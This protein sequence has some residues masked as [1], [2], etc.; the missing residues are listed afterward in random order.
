MTLHVQLSLR[1]GD[2]LGRYLLIPPTR[3]KSLEQNRLLSYYLFINMNKQQVESPDYFN[4][5]YFPAEPSNINT[6]SSFQKLKQPLKKSKKSLNSASCS[7]PSLWN[8]LPVDIKRS[9]SINSFKHNVKNYYLTK[10]EHTGL[11]ISS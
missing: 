8:K 3:E 7:G 2:K 6:R 5:I 10:M 1:L 4:E 9:G 11:L